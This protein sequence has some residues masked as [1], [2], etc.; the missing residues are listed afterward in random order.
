MES[1]TLLSHV[2]L[3]DVLGHLTYAMMLYGAYLLTKRNK[4]GWL[5]RG[6]GNLVWVVIGYLTGM[7]SMMFWSSFIWLNDLRGY[8]KWREYENSLSKSE[9]PRVAKILRSKDKGSVR[10]AGGG[11]GIKADGKPR[12]GYNVKSKS[13]VYATPLNRS[14]K[15]KGVP[16]PKRTG[17]SKAQR[18]ARANSGSNMEATEKGVRGVNRIH[19]SK[20]ISDPYENMA[21]TSFRKGKKR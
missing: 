10:S 5:L 12:A 11:C 14:E 13:P 19:E 2:T 16:K 1:S 21:D 6:F 20:Y 17:T 4:Y 15:H 9:G 3:P 18:K 8:Y 7:T